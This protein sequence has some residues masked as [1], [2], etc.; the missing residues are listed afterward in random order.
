MD[1]LGPTLPLPPLGPSDLGMGAMPARPAAPAAPAAPGMSSRILKLVAAGIAGGLG[2]GA[3]TGI[4]QGMNQAQQTKDAQSRYDQQVAQQNYRY[5]EQDYQQQAR[6]YETDYSRRQQVVTQN[7]DALRKATATMPD[8]AT[9]DRTVETFATGLQQMGIR[10]NA[11]FLRSAAPYA[12]P[13]VEARAQEAFE[14]YLKNPYNKQLVDKSPQEALIAKVAFDRDGD[15][16]AEQVTVRELALLAQ[17]PFAEDPTTGKLSVLPKGTT[18]E[19]KANADGIL[20]TLMDQA[21]A[22]GK[23]VEDPAIKLAL[24]QEAMR[25]AGDASRAPQT[26]PTGLPTAQQRRIDSLS[27]GFDSQMA[28]KNTQIMSEAASF[29]QSLD[30]NTKNPA[31]DQ[32]LIYAFAKA[33]DPNSVVREGEYATVQRYAQSWAESFGFNAA[34]IF[35]NTPFLTPV[36]RQNMKATIMARFRAA[37][38]QYQTIRK[39]YVDRANRITGQPDGDSYFTDYGGAFPEDNAPEAPP[40]GAPPASL[41]S[42]EEYK[43]RQQG[44][45]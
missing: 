14:R 15:G 6:Q 11:N 40:V 23:N 17:M 10:V 44:R 5:A 30:P 45:P 27:K 25:M 32:A 37:R 16:I 41:P 1:E 28:V 19:M 2:P 18:S 13:K 39:S 7:I 22:E 9:Y 24:Q 3:G 26:A 34:R 38:G 33:M 43:Q 31:D 36:S 4:L 42:Y 12:A 35:S 20:Q 8:K 21:R 29:A